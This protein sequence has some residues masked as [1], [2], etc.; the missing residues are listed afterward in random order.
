MQNKQRA[1]ASFYSMYHTKNTAMFKESHGAA[2]MY[3]SSF[4]ADFKGPIPK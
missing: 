4:D 3:K 2:G 1:T